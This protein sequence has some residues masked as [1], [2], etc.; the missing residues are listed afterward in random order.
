MVDWFQEAAKRVDATQLQKGQDYQL[1]TD[2]FSNFRR[3]G[4]QFGL[5]PY[6]AAEFNC[7]QKLERLKAL[8]ANGRTPQ[9]EAVEDTYKDLTVYA[10][11]AYAMYLAAMAEKATAKSTDTDGSEPGQHEYVDQ[12]PGHWELVPDR[13]LLGSNACPNC[14]H[15]ETIH[16]IVDRTVPL[17]SRNLRIECLAPDCTDDCKA[18]NERLQAELDAEREKHPLMMAGQPTRPGRSDLVSKPGPIAEVLKP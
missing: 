14:G 3:T 9:N 5:T 4:E 7:V 12:I 10:T 2:P 17:V 16:R 8:R 18:W 15:F 1:D 11:L 13:I 6:E